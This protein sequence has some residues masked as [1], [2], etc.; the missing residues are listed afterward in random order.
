MLLCELINRENF[1][2]ENGVHNKNSLLIVLKGAF[3]FSFDCESYIARVN[4][5]VFFPKNMRFSRRVIESLQCL[6]IQADSAFDLLN[7]GLLKT[8][9]IVRQNNTV[10][11]LKEA[12]INANDYLI[13]HYVNDILISAESGSHFPDKYV[14]AVTD[15]INRNYALPLTLEELSEIA[16]M[17]K[18]G[19]ILAFKRS[20]GKTPIEYLNY[21]RLQ[22]S[23]ELLK[24]TDNSVGEISE[25]C[26][27]SNV[28]YFSNIFKKHIGISPNMFRK[29]MRL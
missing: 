13:N 22:N 28:Y 17:S 8:K 23:K 24:N 20:M 18:Q 5:I 25:L 14:N 15:Y 1:I 4:D 16:N 21:I 11:H 19:L 10:M 7:C 27:F 29:N 6:Y 12:V 2:L 3:E 26:G 9:D